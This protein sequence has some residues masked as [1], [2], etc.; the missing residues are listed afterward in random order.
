M[1]ERKPGC[2]VD[3]QGSPLPT[4]PH[5]TCFVKGWREEER[6]RRWRKLSAV[7][8]SRPT[9]STPLSTPTPP[10]PPPGDGERR[11]CLFVFS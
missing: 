4:P 11:V 6:R 7:K 8:S 5:P 3:R 10:H 1:V 9:S 2:K